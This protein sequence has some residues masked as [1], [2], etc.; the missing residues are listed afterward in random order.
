MNICINCKH[1]KTPDASS[2]EFSK[3][4]FG[5]QSSPVTGLLPS[6]LELPYCKVQRCPVGACGPVGANYEAAV[7]HEETTHE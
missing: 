7:K 6:S 2:P 5:A 1:V 3:C 4:T